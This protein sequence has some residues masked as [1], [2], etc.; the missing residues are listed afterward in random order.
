M[1]D[2]STTISVDILCSNC[3]RALNAE[4]SSIKDEIAVD[5]CD[6]CLRDKYDEG[7]EQG[8]LDTH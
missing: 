3:G 4:H 8:Q 7:Y 5:L 6:D 2:I 1:V